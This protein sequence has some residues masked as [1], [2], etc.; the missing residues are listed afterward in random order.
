MYD[1]VAPHARSP[2]N[3]PHSEEEVKGADKSNAGLDF[4]VFA[5]RNR[6]H[7]KLLILSPLG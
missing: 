7:C 4:G 6:I 3:F 1:C 5:S 2:P